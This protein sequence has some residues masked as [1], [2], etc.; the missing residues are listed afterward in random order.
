MNWATV[1]QACWRGAGQDIERV[2][3]AVRRR[4]F[5]HALTVS[6]IVP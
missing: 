2:P 3:G 6:N 4:G 5:V 1:E